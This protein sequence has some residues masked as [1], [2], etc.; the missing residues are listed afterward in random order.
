M[1]R[2][3]QSAA[4]ASSD[5]KALIEQSAT[6]VAGGTRLVSEAADK[7]A[8][9]L[10]AIRENTAAL[11]AIAR[12][13]RSQASAIEEVT[14]AVRQMDEMTQHNA[15]LV[16]QTNAAIE[17]TEAQASKLDQIVD[18]FVSDDRKSATPAPRQAPVAS[19]RRPVAASGGGRAA[20]AAQTLED[21]AEF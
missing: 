14:I 15:A 3:A 16:E 19:M 7:L 12:D 5:V 10:D 20:A 1:R 8:G 13:S 17:Q 21:W 18:I 11:E 6:E 2:L 9:T 4:Q